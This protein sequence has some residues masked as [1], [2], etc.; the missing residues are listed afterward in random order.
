MRSHAKRIHGKVKYFA[1]FIDDCAGWRE[2]YFLK[3]TSDALP[4]FKKYKALVENQTGR[5]I[6]NLQSDNRREYCNKEFDDYLGSSGIKR[7]LTVGHTPQQN[8][9]AERRNHTI[10]EMARCSGKKQSPLQITSGID[11]L[12]EKFKAKAHSKSGQVRSQIFRILELLVARPS[13]PT[14]SFEGVH[15]HKILRRS[16][17]LQSLDTR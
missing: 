5:K 3:N 15:L 7:R 12:L 1:T 2:V 6:K 17:S 8:G 13:H 14:C 16:E 10:A 4:T 11:V 9:V